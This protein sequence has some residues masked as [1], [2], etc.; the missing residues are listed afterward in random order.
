MSPCVECSHSVASWRT[1]CSSPKL[2][3]SYCKAFIM[4]SA[5]AC[6]CSVQ[7]ITAHA[8]IHNHHHS[9]PVSLSNRPHTLT[10][11]PS[12]CCTHA[13]STKPDHTIRSTSCGCLPP[14][15]S[16]GG[17]W[18]V[19]SHIVNAYQIKSS[20]PSSS[21]F[22]S[23]SLCGLFI[24]LSLHQGLLITYITNEI[25]FFCTAD[26]SLLTVA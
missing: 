10:P 5:P 9:S 3:W 8:V 19:G 24:F 6:C 23:T 16:G 26:T 20:S 7:I 18:T 4:L 12:P 15:P 21:P 2:F 22:L 25:K 14:I 13:R 17:G 1:H 11:S